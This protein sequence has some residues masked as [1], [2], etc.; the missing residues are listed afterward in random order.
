MQTH[1]ERR[2]FHNSNMIHIFRFSGEKNIVA[3]RA[4][5]FMKY[6][7]TC[8]CAIHLSHFRRV[9]FSFIF[10]SDSRHPKGRSCTPFRRTISAYL[11]SIRDFVHCTYVECANICARVYVR[12]RKTRM[13]KLAGTLPEPS[14]NIL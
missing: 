14:V 4:R 2:T 1:Y 10:Y 8:C 11:K 5:C 9:R 7:N 3:Y 12:H 13:Q 6:V